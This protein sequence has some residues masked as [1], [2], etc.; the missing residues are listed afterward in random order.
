[1]EKIIVIDCGHDAVADNCNIGF[2]GKY[3]E[4]DGNWEYGLKLKKYLVLEGFRVIM[5]RETNTP[6]SLTNRARIAINNKADMFL[7]I[8]SDANSNISVGGT[9]VFYSV[10]RIADKQLADT[11]GNTVATSYGVKFKGSKIRAS[12]NRNDLDYYTVINIAANYKAMTG[13]S[14]VY[15]V[16]HVL[17]LE[18]AFHSNKLEEQLLLNETISDKSAKDLANKLKEILIG[19]DNK[20]PKDSWEQ[21]L[22]EQAID[23]LVK[24]QLINNSEDWKMKDL[25]NESVPLWLFFEMCNRLS[26]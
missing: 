10:N 23:E 9:T 8:H 18:R 12:T 13:D 3:K 4:Y 2:S 16:P 21:Q 25:K 14:G 1:M 26:K 6:L 17:L 19:G 11:I 24:K 15:E 7:S 5:T 20:V 22:G